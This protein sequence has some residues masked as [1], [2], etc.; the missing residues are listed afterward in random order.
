MN[1]A[2]SPMG[3]AVVKAHPVTEQYQDDLVDRWD[4]LIDWNKRQDGEKTFF[5]DQLTSNGARRVL[6]AACGTG[7]HAVRLTRA[8]FDVTAL[9]I[10]PNMV[11]RTAENARAHGV[12]FK[13]MV[14]DWLELDSDAAP[15]D[16]I[17]CLG[18]SFPHL[19]DPADRSKAL[20]NFYSLLRPG[21]QL[22]LD[23]RN[24]DAIR[25]GQY[26]NTSGL[27]YSGQGTR[28]TPSITG[29]ICTFQYDFPDGARHHLRV[30]AI[31]RDTM[32]AE[33]TAAGF[34][35]ITSYGD[36]QPDYDLHQVGFH[37]HVARRPA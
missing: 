27:Y 5:I 28:V 22:I 25:V 6:D 36:F 24:F 30:A 23:H 18:S 9:D 10:C 32:R 35:D 13:M 3:T 8:G 7:Y 14:R 1:V 21:G 2:V 20:K 12:R 37:I 19:L 11:A 29:D 15:F 4:N 17:V 16:A 31:P 34:N 33:L 26:A